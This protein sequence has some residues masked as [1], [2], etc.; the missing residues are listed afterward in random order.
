[1]LLNNFAIPPRVSGEA[2]LSVVR[3]VR[4]RHPG[5]DSPDAESSREL[6]E[7]AIKHQPKP[8]PFT[9]AGL[10]A[11][12]DS[13]LGFGYILGSYSVTRSPMSGATES[14]FGFSQD[15]DSGRLVMNVPQ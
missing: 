7:I 9:V 12:F 4:Q 13:T 2:L 6:I 1:M 10:D 8:L 3:A 11:D 5:E 15:V 14:K